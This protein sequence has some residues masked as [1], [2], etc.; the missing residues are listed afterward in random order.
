MRAET[1]KGF[2]DMLSG[3]AFSHL[4]ERS[5]QPE[6]VRCAKFAGGGKYLACVTEAALRVFD[7]D[8]I[9]S[10]PEG[11]VEPL[12]SIE[13]TK[14][15]S[16]YGYLPGHTYTV[17][18]DVEG[19]CVLFAGLDGTIRSLELGSDVVTELISPPGTPPI[20]QMQLLGKT[21]FCLCQPGVPEIHAKRQQPLIQIWDIGKLTG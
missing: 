18:E 5:Y 20:M 2:D 6:Y 9:L 7:A 17:V 15:P 10:A 12:Y 8:R 11:E 16:E 4:D 19:R 21:L 3:K 1:E 13:P 14:V